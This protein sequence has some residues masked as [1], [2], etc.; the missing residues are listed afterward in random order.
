MTIAK[1]HLHLAIFLQLLSYK[2]T[3]MHDWDTIIECFL[4]QSC[5][6]MKKIQLN[7]F[8]SNVCHHVIASALQCFSLP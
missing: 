7:E 2:L 4:T 8:I 3:Q 5:S 6:F 1:D